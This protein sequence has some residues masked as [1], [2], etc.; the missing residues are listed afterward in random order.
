MRAAELE[1]K[2]NSLSMH[3]E[4]ADEPVMLESILGGNA[5]TD[6]ASNASSRQSRRPSAFLPDSASERSKF[7]P[8]NRSIQDGSIE[9]SV[10]SSASISSN[11]GGVSPTIPL[12]DR[13]CIDPT[14]HTHESHSKAHHPGLLRGADFC[15]AGKPTKV[16]SQPLSSPDPQSSSSDNFSIRSGRIHQVL[17]SG[18]TCFT[19]VQVAVPRSQGHSRAVKVRAIP[20]EHNL[21][22]PVASHRNH[23]LGLSK[24]RPFVSAGSELHSPKS[25]AKAEKVRLRASDEVG[26][27]QAL[28][29]RVS[30]T[31]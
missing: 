7:G 15:G 25:P 22:T 17:P 16:M 14:L 20:Q 29:R 18:E 2:N 26:A 4:H 5:I 27:E 1:D 28:R 30:T 9:P 8:E 10:R 6:T 31:V 19:N 13:V 21:Y 24:V 23:G 3:H 12:L 11:P